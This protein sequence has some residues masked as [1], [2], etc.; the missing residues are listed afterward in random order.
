ME[1][2]WCAVLAWSAACSTSLVGSVQYWPKP[3]LEPSS[4][5]MEELDLESSPD[6]VGYSV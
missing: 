5:V 6:V 2:S 1:F 3:D 4:N